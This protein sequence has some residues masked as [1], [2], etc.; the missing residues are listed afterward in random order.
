MVQ[1]IDL[2]AALMKYFGYQHF[3][4]GQKEILEALLA[5]KNVLGIL[6][7]GVGKSL[8]YQLYGYLVKKTVVIVSPLISLMQDQVANLYLRGEKKAIALNSNLTFAQRREILAKLKFFRFIYVSPE[9]LKN[10]AVL[11]ALQKLDLGLFVVDEAHCISTWGPDFR[12]DYLDLGKIRR[13]LAN[14]LTLALTA[15]ATLKVEMQIK[16]ALFFDAQ[17]KVVR[18]A[19]NRANIFLDVE[20]V[21]DE[22]QKNARLLELTTNLQGPGLIYFSSKKKAEEINQLILQKSDLKSA[23]Y[24]AGMANEDRF[25]VLEQFLR[26]ELDIICATSAFGMGINKQNIRYIIHYHLPS[27]LEDYVQEYGRCSRDGQKGAAI[28]LYQDSDL[29]LQKYL[30]EKTFPKLQEIAYFFKQNKVLR[31]ILQENPPFDLLARYQQLG[32]TQ[33]QVERLIKERLV[34]RK[35]ALDEIKSYLGSNCLRKKIAQYFGDQLPEQANCCS[36]QNETVSLSQLGQKKVA[37]AKRTTFEDY[38]SVLKKLFN[39]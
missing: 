1:T 7:T 39:Q 36:P 30:L 24:H 37:L 17:T 25:A 28:I 23:V 35:Q 38:Q 13:R 11:A 3:K 15:T 5:Q 8:C 21:S 10:P 20:E 18:F 26:D 29:D 14:P 19:V 22:A 6:P 2:T 34:E 33:A 12:P 31:Q 32:F 27:S 9:L 4:P 16:Q